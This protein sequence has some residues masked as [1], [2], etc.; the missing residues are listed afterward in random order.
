ME[1]DACSREP[2]AWLVGLAQFE[3]LLAESEVPV[4]LY[5][6]RPQDNDPNA[7]ASINWLGSDARL[8]S[9]LSVLVE[10]AFRG[11]R[12]PRRDF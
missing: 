5:I 7:G 6:G 10:A 1:N 12:P 3:L 2:G 11:R 8:L 9:L 4:R